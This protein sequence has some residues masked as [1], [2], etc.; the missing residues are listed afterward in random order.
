MLEGV[1]SGARFVGLGSCE[2]FC[3]ACGGG[4][5]SGRG[6]GERCDNEETIDDTES[7]DGRRSLVG[8][9]SVARVAADGTAAPKDENDGDGEA[10]DRHSHNLTLQSTEPEARIRERGQNARH[11]TKLLWAEAIADTHV[12]SVTSH[13]LMDLSSE[14]LNR[15][16]PQGWHTKSFTQ[17]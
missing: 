9:G 14:P 1:R 5:G 11:V 8:A 12:P 7:S 6:V 13:T 4:S 17:F 15:Y 16:F 10:C 2:G 3:C